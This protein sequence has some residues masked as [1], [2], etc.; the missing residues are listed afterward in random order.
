ML[1]SEVAIETLD[2]PDTLSV[3]AGTQPGS[4]VKISGKGV[5]NLGRRG[6]GDLLVR[7]DVQVPER[8]GRRERPLIED[9]AERRGESERPLKGR[10]R[11]PGP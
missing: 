9:F 8:L 4:V 6:R 11:P 7:V 5:P 2:G 3:P 1:G 10:L